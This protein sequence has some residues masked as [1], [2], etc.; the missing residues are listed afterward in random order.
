MMVFYA[1]LFSPL[2]MALVYLIGQIKEKKFFFIYQLLCLVTFPFIFFLFQDQSLFFRD[3]VSFL[4]SFLL[5]ILLIFTLGLTKK[6][7]NSFFILLALLKFF[8]LILFFIKHALLF[9]LCWEFSLIPLYFIIGFYGEEKRIEAAQ[10]FFL[11]M[12]ISSL[13]M[14]IALI[15]FSL[16]SQTFMI[17]QLKTQTDHHTWLFYGFLIALLVKLPLVPFHRWLT[18]AHVHAPMEGSIL[19]AGIFLKLAGFLFF[20]FIQPFFSKEWLAHQNLFFIW[21]L[22]SFLY[23]ALAASREMKL[24]R[25]IAYASIG[26][27]SYI[28]MGLV[29]FTSLSIKMSLF[30]MVNHAFSS[31]LLFACVGFLK[32][33]LKTDQLDGSFQGLLK[34]F[35]L[36][37]VFFLFSLFASLGLPGFGN[38]IA[39][40]FLLKE[41]IQFI[42]HALLFILLGFILT[43]FYHLRPVKKVFFGPK[44]E[45]FQDLSLEEGFYFGLLLVLLIMVGF[46]P[47]VFFNLCSLYF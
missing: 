43:T 46:Y 16:L 8:T 25:I 26:H 39:E 19:L 5:E 14:L 15:D 17:N 41:F 20:R 27:M 35:P 12:V 28:F 36:L 33:S 22:F 21:G 29:A 44:K 38:F 34:T 23:V 40:F 45:E 6:R 2:L 4:F 18:M 1:Y 3:G 10:K 24:K 37:G 11:Y 30:Q 47:Q 7:S 42:P 32:N 9:Y 31:A 13:P